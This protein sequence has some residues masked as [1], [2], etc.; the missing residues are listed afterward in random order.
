MEIVQRAE[1]CIYVICNVLD[2]CTTLVLLRQ[3][4]DRYRLIEDT[5]DSNNQDHEET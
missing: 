5:V 4:L 2:M 3:I 1:V